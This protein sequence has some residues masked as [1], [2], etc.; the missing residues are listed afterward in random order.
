MP[1][2]PFAKGQNYSL[3]DTRN[4]SA[5]KCCR[6][7]RTDD[8]KRSSLQNR[9]GHWPITTMRFRAGFGYGKNPP[10]APISLWVRKEGER[11][12]NGEGASESGTSLSGTETIAAAHRRG[13]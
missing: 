10:K 13:L 8:A 6:S 2:N 4:R 7:L 11:T 9:A 1:P 12:T 5:G 3:D